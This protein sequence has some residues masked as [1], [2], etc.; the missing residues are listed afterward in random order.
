MITLTEEAAAHIRDALI[1]RNKGIGIRLGVKSSGCSGFSYIM[2]YA[3]G[4]NFD[5]YEFHHDNLKILV[6]SEH[7]PYLDGM[8]VD[9]VK[10][11]LNEGFEFNN[12]NSKGECGCGE[13]FRVSAKG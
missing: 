10:K 2:E 5:D 8:K 11:G 3:D 13:S 7:I 6:S 1:K 9:Y 12:P 4:L